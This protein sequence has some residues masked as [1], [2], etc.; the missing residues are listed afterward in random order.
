MAAGQDSSDDSSEM[1]DRW[2]ELD[3]LVDEHK[4]EAASR[5]A[6]EIRE[7]A[8]AA[9]EVE[10]WTRGLIREVQLR[11]ALHGFETA[12]ELL[13]SEPWP[14]EPFSASVLELFYANSLQTYLQAYSWEIR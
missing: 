12:V 8:R 6:Q 10:S 9:G 14:E 4:L 11:T 2:K 3:G 1:T 7:A 5:L 13:R